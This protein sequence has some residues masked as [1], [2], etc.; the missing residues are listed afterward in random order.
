[1]KKALERQMV[2]EL[3]AQGDPRMFGK[4]HIFDQYPVATT[5][6]ANYFN[7]FAKGEKVKAG[8]VNPGDYETRSVD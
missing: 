6:V 7:R 1:M 3:Q 8:W 4:G 5:P 2:A